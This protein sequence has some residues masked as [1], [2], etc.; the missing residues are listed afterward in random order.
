MGSGCD[1]RWI[2]SD[3]VTGFVKIGRPRVVEDDP[4]ERSSHIDLYEKMAAL[5]QWDACKMEETVFQENIRLLKKDRKSTR[6]NSS[7]RL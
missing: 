7:H 3:D 6:L 1:W 5:A 2:M 4:N